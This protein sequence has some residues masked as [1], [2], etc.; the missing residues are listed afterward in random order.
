MTSSHTSLNYICRH[1]TSKE[2]H[3]LR[4]PVDTNL[5]GCSSN[6]YSCAQA[7]E[8]GLH[9]S[10]PTGYTSIVLTFQVLCFVPEPYPWTQ[11]TDKLGARSRR[12]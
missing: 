7:K 11:Q 1:P 8:A 5:G 10:P 2:G 12:N 9:L 4:F 3:G 6:K